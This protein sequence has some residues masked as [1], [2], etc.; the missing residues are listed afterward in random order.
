MRCCVWLF[1]AEHPVFKAHPQ[2]SLSQSP[3]LV[4]GCVLFHSMDGPPSVCLSTHG[5]LGKFEYIDFYKIGKGLRLCFDPMQ[6][7]RLVQVKK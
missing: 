6:E 4:H 7:S 3:I 1:F 5:R 2:C